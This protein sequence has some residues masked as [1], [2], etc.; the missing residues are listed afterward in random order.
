MA[1][2]AAHITSSLQARPSIFE[3]IAQESLSGLLYPSFKIIVQFL[4]SSNSQRYQWLSEWN[5]E[6]FLGINGLLQLHYL[7]TKGY[8]SF[9]KHQGISLY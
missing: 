1:E 6:V 8:I 5:E 9:E 7:N 2:K 3:L 4:E